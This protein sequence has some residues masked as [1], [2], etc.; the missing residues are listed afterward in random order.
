MKGRCSKVHDGWLRT[1]EIQV[2]DNGILTAS[3]HHRLTG[4]IGPSVDLL[5]RHVRRNVDEV[6][7]SGFPA[8]LQM[9]PPSHSSPAADDVENGFQLAVMVRSG[10]CIRLDDDCAG[11]QFAGSCSG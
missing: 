5:M 9:I 11:P 2:D 7:R 3:Y 4:F 1:F 6:A 8:E 10:L